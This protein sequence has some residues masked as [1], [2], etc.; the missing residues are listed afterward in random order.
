VPTDAAHLRAVTA[1]YWVLHLAA[2]TC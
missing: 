1:I 2:G